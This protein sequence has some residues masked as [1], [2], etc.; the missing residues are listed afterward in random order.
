ML[1]SRT[2]FPF[3]YF[4]AIVC[5]SKRSEGQQFRYLHNVSV[6]LKNAECKA[7]LHPTRSVF[8]FTLF[9]R[10]DFSGKVMVFKNKILNKWCCLL[11]GVET[12]QIKQNGSSSLYY[13]IS[14]TIETARSSHHGDNQSAT[15]IASQYGSCD[16]GMRGTD[17]ASCDT[18]YWSGYINKNS[19]DTVLLKLQFSNH[20]CAHFL[21]KTQ[22][23]HWFNIGTNPRDK[24]QNLPS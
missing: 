15:A 6:R 13:S 17:C 18:G 2:H 21:G 16:F 12:L 22:F 19:S 20:L 11:E 14:V 23:A 10:N 4:I 8:C 1:T 24:P 5:F 9:N 3:I 7:M